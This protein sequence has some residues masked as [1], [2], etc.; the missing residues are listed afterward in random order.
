LIAGDPMLLASD[1]QGSGASETRAGSVAERE[2]ASAAV[3]RWLLAQLEIAPGCERGSGRQQREAPR[4]LGAYCRLILLS[5]ILC[6]FVPSKTQGRT[7]SRRDLPP[8]RQNRPGSSLRLGLNPAPA[9]HGR[10][11]VGKRHH[12]H[13]RH[14]I[15]GRRLSRRFA[16]MYR[17]GRCRR[18]SRHVT[19]IVESTRLTPALNR[20]AIIS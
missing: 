9:N 19:D 7:Y 12:P 6:P 8:R 15:S 5:N 3:E 1:H 10:P 18:R 20:C 16:V 2:R 14:R 4:T 13:N 11:S 17:F